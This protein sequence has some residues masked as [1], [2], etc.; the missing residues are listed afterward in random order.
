MKNRNQ[1]KFNRL[2]EQLKRDEFKYVPREEKRIDWSSYDRAQINEINDMLLLIREAVDQAVSRLGLDETAQNG[3][4]RPP[5]PPADLAKAILIQQY[6]GVSNRTAEGLTRLFMEKM[7]IENS[8]SYKT[9]ERAYEDPLVVLIL[10]E[11]FR[12]TQEPVRER[13]HVFSPD[14]TG[15]P[16]SLKAELGERPPQG[17]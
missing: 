6:F 11:V 2:M 14:G 1:E 12:L 7:G 4:G 3:P 5:Y 13:E 10:R 15:L 16:T 17:R 8:F 9:I